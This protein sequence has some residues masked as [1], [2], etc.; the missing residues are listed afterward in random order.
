MSSQTPYVGLR[1]LT[2]AENDIFFGRQNC[3]TELTQLLTQ[4]SFTLIIGEAYGGKTSL[5]QCGLQAH[6]MQQGDWHIAVMTPQNDPFAQLTDA[7]LTDNALGALYKQQ[8]KNE[9]TAKQFLKQG[10]ADSSLGLHHLL[11]NVPLPENHKLLIICDQFEQ[12]FSYQKTNPEPALEFVNLLLASGKA[13]PLKKNPPPLLHIML[14]LRSNQLDYCANFPDL[15]YAIK[16]QIYVVPRLSL[17]E[18]YEVIV[19]PA[20]VHNGS[21]NEEL[22]AQLL[23]DAEN[24]ADQLLLLQ[25]LLMRMWNL[26]PL[27]LE[28]D[29]NLNQYHKNKVI[30]LEQTLSAHLEEAYFEL[31]D[32]Q[33]KIAEILFRRLLVI[34]RETSRVLHQ[35]APIES[36]AQL[37][38]VS[39]QDVVEVINVFA[40]P[41]RNFLLLDKSVELTAQT[42]VE[43]GHDIIVCYWQRLEDWGKLE[44]QAGE[45]YRTIY[46]KAQ[47]HQHHKADFLDYSALMKIWQWYQDD[48]P[49]QVWAHYYQ[50][51][52]EIIQRYIKHSIIYRIGCALLGITIAGL[53]FVSTLGAWNQDVAQKEQ[54]QAVLNLFNQSNQL[55]ITPQ[56]SVELTQKL[57]NLIKQA[58]KNAD[59]W[60]YYGVGLSRQAK[61]IPAEIA[62]TQARELLPENN[63]VLFYL[64]ITQQMQQ[65]W[66]AAEQSFSKALEQQPNNALL[67]HLLADILV[68]K[69]QFS[70]A[71][72]RYNTALA[73]EPKND[74]LLGKIAQ[75]LD[76]QNKPIEARAF[77]NQAL[78]LNPKNESNWRN[79]GLLNKKQGRLL[80]AENCFRWAVKNEPHSDMNLRNLATVL[81]K[82]NKLAEAIVFFRQATVIHPENDKNWLG[83]GEVL[84]RDNQLDAALVAYRKAVN[85]AKNKTNLRHLAELLLKQHKDTEAMA[86]YNQALAEP[87]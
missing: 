56:N 6:L 2:F 70:Q 22:A 76:L 27:G 3:I 24:K 63:E 25:H 23:H 61:W 33:F 28:H 60:F 21:V 47:Q 54:K 38:Q 29:L 72:V 1:A 80:Q 43:I 62:F 46:H 37:A 13:Y 53:I 20:L 51:D 71:I 11:D 44:R 14:V 49:Q 36:V 77:F 15:A 82:Q 75:V 16:R 78:A 32:N 10:L 50:C 42:L 55:I 67:L 4:Q 18:L 68:E 12:I 7:L 39:W 17:A 79:F 19:K 5:L 41:P 83:L 73:L 85:L 34:N 81:A 58:P 35:P 48:P 31:R 64:G 74:V 87:N 30:G 9:A 65:K 40:R 86:V 45:N 8:F 66:D 57:E 84:S 52:L 26:V 69:K 59:A